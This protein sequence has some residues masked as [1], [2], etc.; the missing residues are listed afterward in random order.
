M[1]GANWNADTSLDPATGFERRPPEVV[2]S[3][4]EA[5]K[6]RDEQEQAAAKAAED[7]KKK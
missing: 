3:E 5:M 7:K 1:P 2:K 6:A 4:V